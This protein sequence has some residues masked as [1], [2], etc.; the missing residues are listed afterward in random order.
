[1]VHPYVGL[2]LSLPCW[3]LTMQLYIFYFVKTLFNLA[4]IIKKIVKI[5][6]D[7]KI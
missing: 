7:M 3:V 5:K 1:M 2:V 6:N 4:K